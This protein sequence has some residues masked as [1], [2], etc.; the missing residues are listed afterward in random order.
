M[1]K[2][3]NWDEIVKRARASGKMQNGGHTDP[4][5]QPAEEEGNG[6]EGKMMK[7]EGKLKKKEKLSR[8]EKRFKKARKKG[9]K[10]FKFRKKG[11]SIFKKRG[12]YSTETAEEK[13]IRLWME[14]K[15]RG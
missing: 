13:K 2:D 5:V 4:T 15:D 11:E 3:K 8:F 6:T 10:T 12:V 14:G 1:A 9:K 7:T